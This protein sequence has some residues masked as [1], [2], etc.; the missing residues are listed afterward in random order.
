MRTIRVVGHK[1][2]NG[3]NGAS[4]NQAVAAAFGGAIA[5]AAI[6]YGLGS[7]NYGSILG[8]GGGGLQVNGSNFITSTSNTL[9]RGIFQ[10]TEN[11]IIET[12]GR[13]Y[14]NETKA[15][16]KMWELATQPKYGNLGREVGAW[17]TDKGVLVLPNVG[18]KSAANIPSDATTANFYQFGFKNGDQYITYESKKM[19]IYGSIHTHQALTKQGRLGD[20]YGLSGGNGL[21]GDIE[22]AQFGTIGKPVFAIGANNSLYGYVWGDYGGLMKKHT[23]FWKNHNKGQLLNGTFKLLPKLKL[24][25]PKPQ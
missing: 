12:Q 20:F 4:P 17:L 2:N 21:F 23:G 24:A 7:I 18:V 9:A 10:L 25:I 22:F 15:Y 16:N 1:T 14:T 11:Q 19:F 6:G 13:L 8:K 5:G 3:G